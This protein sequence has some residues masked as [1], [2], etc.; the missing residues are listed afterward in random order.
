L[1]PEHIQI[2]ELGWRSVRNDN[3]M[4]LSLTFSF[5]IPAYAGIYLF[6]LKGKCQIPELGWRSSGMT[7][8]W[9]LSLTF[10]FVIPAYA[11][12]YLFM[13]KGKC[14][15]PELR[16]RSVRNDNL[17]GCHSHFPL[18]FLRMQESISWEE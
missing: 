14:Q 6:M 12:I 8:F 16:W 4:G 2:P 5:V 7:I 15:I 18:S 9:S 17:L 1:V 3:L 11:G 13:L 10:S